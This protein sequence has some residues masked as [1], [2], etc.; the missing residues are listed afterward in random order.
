M[1]EL[2]NDRLVFSFPEVHP[3]AKLSIDF[4]RT[5]RIPDDNKTYP[6]PPG[7]GSFPLKHVDDYSKNVPAAWNDHGG[8]MLPMYQAEA[9]WIYFSGTYIEDRYHEYPFAVKIASGK[10]NAVDGLSWADGLSQDPQNYIVSPE[11]PWIDGYCVERGTIRQFVAMPLG[12]GYTAEEQI[13]GKGDVGGLQIQVFPMKRDR[14]EKY[15]PVRP[16]LEY[17]EDICCCE[18]FGDVG[19]A[20]KLEMGLAPGG[21]M[22][23]EIYDD[24]YKLDDWDLTQP[25]R[26]FIHIAN[27]HVWS[28]ITGDK[29]PTKPPTAKEYADA[30]LPWFDYYDENHNALKGSKKL[31]GLKSV[32]EMG[33]GNGESPLPENEVPGN[34]KV[35]NIQKKNKNLVREGSF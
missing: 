12:K 11:Q 16:K 31:A 19:Y 26:C 23:Q 24:P 17:S 3:E 20:N 5:L 2:L 4:Q 9:L 32:K 1:I 6:L 21:K 34:L 29:P 10:I 13:T 18:P 30:G 8:V 25:S 33:D 22:K 15:F 35:H 14:F 7:L 27:S 28:T